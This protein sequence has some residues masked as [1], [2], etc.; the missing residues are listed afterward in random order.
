MEAHEGYSDYFGT[1]A[2]QRELLSVQRK[3]LMF[4]FYE[5]HVKVRLLPDGDE[6]RSELVTSKYTT[7]EQALEAFKD[8]PSGAPKLKH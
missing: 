7:K 4:W 8:W 2:A 3:M 6:E 1:L 5:G